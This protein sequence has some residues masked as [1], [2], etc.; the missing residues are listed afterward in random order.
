[1]D[2]S[3]LSPSLPATPL[4]LL[5]DPTHGNSNG[6]GSGNGNGTCTSAFSPTSWG[7]SA[8]VPIRVA[9]ASTLRQPILKLPVGTTTSILYVYPN[10]ALDM[11][12]GHRKGG[13]LF[14][15]QGYMDQWYSRSDRCGMDWLDFLNRL[16]GIEAEII[17]EETQ[18]QLEDETWA[19]DANNIDAL[20]ESA[21]QDFPDEK[22]TS[23]KYQSIQSAADEIAQHCITDKTRAGH[24]RIIQ[25]F[26]VYMLMLDRKWSPDVMAQSPLDVRAFI[27]KKCGA[28]EKGYEGK[29][30]GKFTTAVSIQAALTYFYK[31]LCPD[32]SKSITDSQ[33]V[34]VFPHVLSL[35]RKFMVGLEKSK[36]AAV[37]QEQGHNYT[38]MLMG[39]CAISWLILLHIEEAT[40]LEFESIDFHPGECCYFEVKLRTQKSAQTGVSHTWKLYANDSDIRICPVCALL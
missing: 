3:E 35:F 17:A 8:F 2:I 18:L 39:C 38:G 19:S 30:A 7:T 31:T 12:L 11:P 37:P 23:E 13:G 29:K 36:A 6:S 10:T 14:L 1:M 5:S 15:E 24:L 26:V 40:N 32:E 33:L 34:L 22:P 21:L 25:A 4:P 27:M 16:G 20:I 9:S 28:V